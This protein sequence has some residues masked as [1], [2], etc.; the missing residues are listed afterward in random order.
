MTTG[1]EG[2]FSEHICPVEFW[3]IRK[4]VALRGVG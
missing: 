3:G 4:G 2:G 1:R